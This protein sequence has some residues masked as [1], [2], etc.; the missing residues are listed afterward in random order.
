MVTVSVRLQIIEPTDHYRL[1]ARRAV[2][3]RINGAPNPQR[4]CPLRANGYGFHNS[5]GMIG[6]RHV[7][8]LTAFGPPDNE[9]PHWPKSCLCGYTFTE[10]DDR[11]FYSEQLWQAED[12]NRYE[13]ADAPVGS[14]WHAYWMPRATPNTKWAGP[15]G[16]CLV[17]RTPGGDWWVDGPSRELPNTRGWTRVGTMPRITVDPGIIMENWRGDIIDGHLVSR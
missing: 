10:Q 15:D 5:E 3:W 6:D 7:E 1:H 8:C 16:L 9:D 12:G 13:L 4:L 11:V 17:V 14:L 2:A